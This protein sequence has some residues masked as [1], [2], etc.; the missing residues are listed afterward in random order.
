MNKEAGEAFSTTARLLFGEP[1]SG[2][3]SY[4]EW[5]LRHLGEREAIK[6]AL[7]EETIHLIKQY[8]FLN[9]IP[10]NRIITFPQMEKRARAMKASP[11]E[12]CSPES[13]FAEFQK[14]AYF[15][16]DI[17]CGTNRNN[18]GTMGLEDTT[19]TY[20]SQDA[21]N[22]RCTG[23]VSYTKFSENAFGC[24]RAFY[25]KY[26]INCYNCVKCTCCFECDSLK[27]SSR[28]YF[29]HNCEN[30]HDALFCS[31]AKNLR[32]AVA[33]VAVGKEEYERLKAILLKHV[34]SELLKKKSLDLDIFNIGGK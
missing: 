19:D 22:S 1:L 5:L 26:C 25:S 16:L 33:N 6:S 31:N 4:S 11:A 21:F 17:R 2:I 12:N 20:N 15:N 13:V 34:L 27:E 7:G 18:E 28:A 32:Y 3:D 8:A 23:Y 14:I 10:R 9:L 29:C 30:V 24:Y